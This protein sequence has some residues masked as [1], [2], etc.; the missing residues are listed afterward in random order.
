MKEDINIRVKTRLDASIFE[1]LEDKIRDLLEKEGIDAEIHDLVTGNITVT[2]KDEMGDTNDNGA[3]DNGVNDNGV[4]DEADKRSII[5]SDLNI[6]GE[7][8]LGEK[9][10][11]NDDLRCR[12]RICGFT[13]EQQEKLRN[14]KFIDMTLINPKD[15]NTSDIY[16]DINEFDDKTDRDII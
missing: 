11:F 10:W 1:I 5:G 2:R 3:N 16:V 9:I 7:L 14:A 4:N 15:D 13:K 6:R 8:I 12:L